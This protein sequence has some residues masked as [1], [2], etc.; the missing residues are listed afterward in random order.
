MTPQTNPG[1]ILD[2][3]YLTN[4]GNGWA[5]TNNEF[6]VKGAD[7]KDLATYQ[8]SELEDWYVWGNDL[9][10]KIRKDKPYYSSRCWCSKKV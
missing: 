7:G 8:G 4:P 10:G 5:L 6:Y 2:W 3:N 9:T 1:P